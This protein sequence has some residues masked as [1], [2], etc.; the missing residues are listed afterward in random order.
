LNAEGRAN[1]SIFLREQEDFPVFDQCVSALVEDLH[2]SAAGG[3]LCGGDLGRVWTD[4]EDQ[5]RLSAAI[6]GRR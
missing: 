2:Q 5:R 3:R 4:A 6:T 1:N